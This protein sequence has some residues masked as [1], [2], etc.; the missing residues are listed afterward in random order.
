VRGRV[1]PGYEP[2]ARLFAR[3]FRLPRRG[4][5][6][7]V[8]RHRGRAVVDIWAGVADSRTGRPWQRDSL[9]LSFST[10][11]GVAA[12]VIHRLADRGLL[13]YDEPVAEFWPSFAAGGKARLTVRQLLTH[14]VGLDRLAPI[15]SSAEE[16]MDHVR[17]EER[18]AA[19]TPDHRP[20]SSA[21]HAI[22]FGWLLAGLARAVTGKGMAELV[23]TE[24]NEPLGLDGL[25][26]GR[27]G[28]GAERVAATLGSLRPLSLALTRLT[29]PRLP[30]GLAPRRVYESMFVPG[31]SELFQAPDPRVLGT[32]MPSANGLFSAESLAVL[33]EAL[34]NDGV[35]G[36]RRLLNPGTVRELSRVQTRAPDR[37]LGLPMLWRLGYHQAFAPGAWLPKAFGHYGYAGSGAWADPVSGLSAAFVSNRVY[38]L[39]QGLG[40][41][42]L[43]RLSRLAVTAANRLERAG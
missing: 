43:T 41:F 39:R 25:H 34:A 3:I 40:D 7:F 1:D 11:K 15:A 18:L 13:G 9:A 10:T 36:G 4:G 30:D 23:R 2:V 5:G 38:P 33:Y 12:T 16:L 32:E 14:Q 31:M 37:S 17:A 21:Y 24:L 27:P 19:H 28:S 22:T 26:I 6:A 29:L 20:G 42:A 8:V 35:A